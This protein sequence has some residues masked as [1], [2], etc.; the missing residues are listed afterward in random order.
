[1]KAKQRQNNRRHDCAIGLD[2]RAPEVRTGSRLAKHVFVVA[3][4]GRTSVRG[5]RAAVCPGTAVPA[6]PRPRGL[7]NV[8]AYLKELLFWFWRGFSAAL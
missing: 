5:G 2:G 3:V 7:A 1:M 8:Q 6:Q 4:P